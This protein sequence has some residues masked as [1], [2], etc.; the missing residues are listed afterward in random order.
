MSDKHMCDVT[1]DIKLH[2]MYGNKDEN[3]ETEKKITIKL[4]NMKI[5]SENKNIFN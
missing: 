1:E 5:F 4:N 2:R 3:R